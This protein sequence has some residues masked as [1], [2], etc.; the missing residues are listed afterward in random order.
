MPIQYACQMTDSDHASAIFNARNDLNRSIH[1][2]TTAGLA[3]SLD[4]VVIRQCQ[5][6]HDLPIL[7][8]KVSR[9]ITGE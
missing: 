4:V 5:D 8:T 6:R 3:V 1:N 7:Q 9:D 2:A